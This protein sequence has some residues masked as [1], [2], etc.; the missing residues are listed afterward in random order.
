[1]SKPK[2]DRKPKLTRAERRNAVFGR[3]STGNTTNE[4]RALI[5]RVQNANIR[6][7]ATNKGA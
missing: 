2:Q 5:R 3:K 1:M 7:Q 6:S 4:D